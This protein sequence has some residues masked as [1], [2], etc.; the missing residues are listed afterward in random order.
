MIRP[1]VSPSPLW[2]VRGV[3]S[4]NAAGGWR[5]AREHSSGAAQWRVTGPEPIPDPSRNRPAGRGARPYMCVQT[6]LYDGFVR[7]SHA[8]VPRPRGVL[9]HWRAGSEFSGAGVE[10]CGAWVVGK[11]TDM[12]GGEAI[13]Q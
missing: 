8:L 7:A 12:G 6:G 2:L 13:G 4:C 10:A 3:G 5:H 1:A 9:G 11:T